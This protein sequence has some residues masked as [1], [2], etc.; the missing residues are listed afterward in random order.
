MLGA[1]ALGFV[2][3]FLI[4]AHEIHSL[5]KTVLPLLVIVPSYLLLMSLNTWWAAKVMLQ[6]GP[7]T[8]STPALRARARTAN[9]AWRTLI[10]ITFG[11]LAALWYVHS[12]K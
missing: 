2:V 12:V 10:G 9:V 3:T 6:V 8:W 7:P 1:A 11:A 5:E 4:L